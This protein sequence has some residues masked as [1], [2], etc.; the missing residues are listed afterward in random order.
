MA[1]YAKWNIPIGFQVFT[2][3]WSIGV[4][5]AIMQGL[6]GG[7]NIVEF[8]SKLRLGTI[9]KRAPINLGQW[10]GF[11]LGHIRQAD[12]WTN[13]IRIVVAFL[14]A[15]STM[16]IWISLTPVGGRG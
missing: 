14:A 6:I 3:L 13:I 7:S 5:F 10:M 12:I 11:I 16:I 2:L 15:L 4:G 8:E 1:T 9:G